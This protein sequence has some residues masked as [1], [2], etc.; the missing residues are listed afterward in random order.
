M[1]NNPI[2]SI[3]LRRALGDRVMLGF[4]GARGTREGNVV[5]YAMIAQQPTMLGEPDGKRTYRLRSVAEHSEIDTQNTNLSRHG[6]MARHTCFFV[7]AISGA[8]YLAGG[9]TR[10]L[11]ENENILHQ[12]VEGIRE[13]Y[14]PVRAF[15]TPSL[16]LR[17]EYYSRGAAGFRN[18]VLAPL[19]R[20]GYG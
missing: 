13:G 6:R 10:R 11:A 2:G 16:L 5:R 17:S 3:G 8:I 18:R 9:D 4:P 14:A 19:F 20:S 15:I 7:T 1:L 12:M